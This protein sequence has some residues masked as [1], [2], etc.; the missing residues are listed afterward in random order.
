MGKD[1]KSTILIAHLTSCPIFPCWIILS[2]REDFLFTSTQSSLHD[3]PKSDLMEEKSEKSLE[4]LPIF[5]S[6]S[7]KNL[8]DIL[9]LKLLFQTIFA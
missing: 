6:T 3:S 4:Q 1:V 8:D 5:T 2:I 9:A 7:T